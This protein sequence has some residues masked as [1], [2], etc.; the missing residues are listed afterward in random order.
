[1]VYSCIVFIYASNK[2]AY[3]IY[4]LVE[5]V[6]FGKELAMVQYNFLN[7]FVILISLIP[8]QYWIEM[9]ELKHW[10]TKLATVFFL[11]MTSP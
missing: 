10:F 3:L 1:M 9:N 8:L 5:G 4:L 2:K 7:K 11:F 6:C